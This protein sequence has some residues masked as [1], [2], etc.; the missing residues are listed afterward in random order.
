MAISG[1]AVALYFEEK[2]KELFPEQSFPET[3]EPETTEEKE[4]ADEDTDESED[5]FIQPRRKRLKTDEKL[6]HI[7]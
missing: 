7:K 3:P 4:K 6:V 2:L 1:K 5:D